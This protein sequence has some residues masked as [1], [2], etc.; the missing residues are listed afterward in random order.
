VESP[1]DVLGIDPDADAE[2]VTRAYRLR[3]KETHP[4]QGGSAREFQRVRDAYEQ[5]RDGVRAEA[6]E[7]TLHGDTRATNGEAA[8]GGD[9]RDGAAGAA[10]EAASATGESDD[11][12]EPD[13]PEG[14]RVQYLNYEVLTDYGWDIDD[15]DLFEKAAA[16]DL[17]RADYGRLL[18]GPRESLLEAAEDRGFAWPYACRGG[19]CANCAVKVVDGDLE[20]SVHDILSADLLERGYR[21]S[22]ISGP[23]TDDLTV[24]FNI[25]HLPD[26]EELR[27]PA[28]RFERAQAND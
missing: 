3:V 13:E 25:K 14:T 11:P 10:D 15:E 1:Y 6:R 9:C 23:T 20:T 12:D 21:L 22:C 5:L 4:D 7:G 16:A 24:V 18:A 27:L 2:E 28:D 19:A 17:D 26:L 8:A